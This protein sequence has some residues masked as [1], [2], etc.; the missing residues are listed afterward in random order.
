MFHVW[1][2]HVDSGVTGK[3]LSYLGFSSGSGSLRP[4]PTGLFSASSPVRRCSS[5]ST[6]PCKGRDLIR[7]RLEMWR[8]GAVFQPEGLKSNVDTLEQVSLVQE[9]LIR[10][11]DESYWRWWVPDFTPNT[12]VML[13]CC[14]FLVFLYRSLLGLTVSSNSSS[15]FLATNGHQP[16]IL[17][18][19]KMETMGISASF[20]TISMVH[21]LAVFAPLGKR[22]RSSSI[23][24]MKTCYLRKADW[25]GGIN[26]KQLPTVPKKS[27]AE[28][29]SAS[30]TCRLRRAG[31]LYSVSSQANMDSFF[32]MTIFSSAMR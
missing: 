2:N 10:M 28:K 18:C 8:W 15:S 30:Q 3:H 21:C 17:F 32:E 20:V 5:A 24:P 12:T 25:C 26:N 22:F 14:R 7:C 4:S 27:S 16:L 23:A 29:W 11:K 31:I 19:L 9:Y 6:F 1:G 13:P